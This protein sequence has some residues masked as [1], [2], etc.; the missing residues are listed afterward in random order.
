VPSALITKSGWLPQVDVVC[1]CSSRLRLVHARPCWL[2][3][4]WDRVWRDATVFLSRNLKPRVTTAGGTQVFMN[5][6]VFEGELMR[7]MERRL[8]A[9][10]SGAVVLTTQLM[11]APAEKESEEEPGQGAG[12]CCWELLGDSDACFELFDTAALTEPTVYVQRRL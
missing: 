11:V 12:C 6:L 2:W 9:L 1:S 8:R 4:A 7:A 5:S 10:R 3:F